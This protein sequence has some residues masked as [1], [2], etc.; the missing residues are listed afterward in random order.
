MT[1]YPKTYLYFQSFGA[2][3]D[4]SARTP[5]GGSITLKLKNLLSREEKM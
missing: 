1:L 3:L 4:S 2:S 5:Q